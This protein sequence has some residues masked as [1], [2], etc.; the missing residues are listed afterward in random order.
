MQRTSSIPS[1]SWTQLYG[2][3]CFMCKFTLF[4]P[5]SSISSFPILLEIGR[6]AHS[7][8]LR[9]LSAPHIWIGPHIDKKL[10]SRAWKGHFRVQELSA[11][12]HTITA[13]DATFK[14]Y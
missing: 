3:E 4:L 2:R 5:F 7:P 10:D 13:T 9:C 12:R 8:W 11:P 6:T 14:Y 1:I